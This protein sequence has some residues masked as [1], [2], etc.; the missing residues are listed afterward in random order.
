MSPIRVVRRRAS[1]LLALSIIGALVFVLQSVTRAP[2]AQAQT[3]VPGLFTCSDGSQ[4][5]SGCGGVGIGYC[6]GSMV[7]NGQACSGPGVTTTSPGCTGLLCVPSATN[8]CPGG[9]HVSNGQSCSQASNS[10]TCPNGSH[11]LAGQSCIYITCPNGFSVPVNVGCPATAPTQLCPDGTTILTTAICP[12][13]NQTPSTPAPT[14]APPGVTV[15]YS[16]GWNI[17]A[18][19]SGTTI[20]GAA[21]SMFTL[22]PGDASYETLAAGAALKPGAGYLAFFPSSTTATLPMVTAASVSVQLPAGQ[23][24]LIG[25]PGDTAAT[26]TGA[27]TVLTFSPSSNSYTPSTSLPPGQGAWAM[28]NNG[29]QATISNSP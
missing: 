12:A 15:T 16:T 26:V 11:P 14:S 10:Q 25:N 22:Q 3:G 20:T 8:T 19:P 27:D 17:V 13:A 28:S 18:G 29:G 4:S 23:F 9:V 5:F 7:G 2:V 21:G 1:L 24:V 6:G